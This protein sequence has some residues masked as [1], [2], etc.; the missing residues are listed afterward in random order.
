MAERSAARGYVWAPSAG[1]AKV[2]IVHAI[3]GISDI[4][5]YSQG[6][7]LL[8]GVDFKDESR[9]VEMDPMTGEL[10]FKRDDNQLRIAIVP[11]L[12]LEM[13]KAYTIL[14]AGLRDKPQTI[15]LEDRAEEPNFPADYPPVVN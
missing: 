11:D 10:E 1:K 3:P 15:V 6:K 7:R 14:L 4:D 13:N 5:V 8:N 9:Y 12:R 2:R